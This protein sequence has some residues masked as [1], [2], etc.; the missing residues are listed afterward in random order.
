MIQNQFP[1]AP[2]RRFVFVAFLLLVVGCSQKTAPPKTGAAG[3][4]TGTVATSGEAA[5]SAISVEA[6]KPAITTESWE[7]RQVATGLHTPA[8]L[9]S[10]PGTDHLLVST[11]KGIYRIEPEESFK[12][13]PE[14]V[15]FSIDSY[16]SGP[17]FSFGALGL[18]CIDET[19]LVVGGGGEPDGKD[20]VS[21]YS[22]G[23]S[24]RDQ[25]L[26]SADTASMSD[27]IPRG[28][29]SHR[30][31]GNFQSV[32]LGDGEIFVGSHGDDSKGWISRVSVD[33]FK[34][35]PLIRL[36]PTTHRDG[37][38]GIILR[39]NKMIV[40]LTGELNERADSVLAIF[41]LATKE[42]EQTIE[43]GLYDITAILADPENENVIYALDFGWAEPDAGGLFSID[44][45]DRVP[46]VVRHA[47][48]RHPTALCR[49]ADGRL[50]VACVEDQGEKE[51]DPAAGALYEIIANS[52]E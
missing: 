51:S 7:T 29:L 35:E 10:Q 9:C 12:Q 38:S 27:P 30:G 5:N 42:L 41:D 28:S 21:S 49:T 39:G 22:I 25:P 37:P 3:S 18:T 20:Y 4:D 52:A 26:S 47:K 45:S 15:G 2:Q 1:E 23:T 17:V 34:I 32:C 14:V 44:L 8:G 33:G 50:F 11:L 13:T 46:T 19:T 48:L 43:T 36:K 6:T 24:R 31:E 40:S 16:G